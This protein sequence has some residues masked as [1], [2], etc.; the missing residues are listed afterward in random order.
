MN[1]TVSDIPDKYCV[2]LGGIKLLVLGA[3]RKGGSGCACPENVLLRNLLS[4]IILNRN[5]VVIVDL[6]AG[7]EHLGRATARS[8]DKMIIVAEPGARSVATA[9]TIM[10][11]AS[12]IGIESFG[13]VANKIQ[14]DRQEEWLSQ[15]LPHELILGSVSHSQ[16]FLE[17]DIKGQTLFESLDEHLESEFQTIYLGLQR[18][19]CQQTARRADG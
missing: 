13:I 6:E 11:L 15:H 18:S 9:R 3:V 10:A 12:D 5:E 2:N 1:P 8:V 16:I 7:I 17:A 19:E 14:D 4:E